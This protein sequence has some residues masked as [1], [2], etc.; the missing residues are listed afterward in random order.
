M[1]TIDA[2]DSI[3]ALRPGTVLAHGTYLSD[4]DIQR[5]AAGGAGVAHNPESNMKLGADRAAPVEA[6][7]AAGVPVGLGTDGPASNNDLDM[8]GEMDT[9]AKLHKFATGDP[10]SLPA[11]RSSGWPPQAV[12]GVLNQQDRI[13]SLEVGKKADIVLVETRRAGMTPLYRPTPISST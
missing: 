1:R 2:L 11:R 7:L 8:F 4:E 5:I 6:L 9:A 13:G 3:G 10:T 12:P